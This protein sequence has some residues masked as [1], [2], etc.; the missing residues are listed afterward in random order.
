MQSILISGCPKSVPH[1]GGGSLISELMAQVYSRHTLAYVTIYAVLPNINNLF[2]KS[3][4]STSCSTIQSNSDTTQSQHRPHSVRAQ[5][6]KTALR[7]QLQKGY[8]SYQHFCLADYTSVGS[9]GTLHWDLIICQNNLGNCYTYDY[10]F[11]TKDT[12]Q[13]QPKGKD[14]QCE[15]WGRGSAEPPCPLQPCKP[16][17]MLMCSPPGSSS[18]LTV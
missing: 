5:S 7:H 14:A 9:H 18:N 8:P 13:I 12:T 1:G 4:M 11:T 2:S 3:T 15:G 10:R 17:S 16:P 6:H